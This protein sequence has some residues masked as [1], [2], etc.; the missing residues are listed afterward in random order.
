M[1]TNDAP[2]SADIAFP[3]KRRGLLDRNTSFDLRWQ[4]TV[5]VVLGLQL[6]DVPRRHRNDAGSNSFAP[7]RLVGLHRETE[8]AAG[9]DENDL[10]FATDGISKH[11]RPARD[12]CRRSV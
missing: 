8:L 7:E 2:L 12:T 5:A 3:A 1:H 9:R 11:I 6:E 4:H 10:G